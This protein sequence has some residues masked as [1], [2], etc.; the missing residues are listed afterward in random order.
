M[1][2]GCQLKNRNLDLSVLTAA[3]ATTQPSCSHGTIAMDDAPLAFRAVLATDLVA[4]LDSDDEWLPEKLEKQVATYRGSC[5]GFV[6]H[7][8]EVWM[9]RGRKVNQKEIHRKQGGWFFE[10]ALERCPHLP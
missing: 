7:T 4:F 1:P 10:R 5:S 9:R 2:D 8:E 6:C 3:W